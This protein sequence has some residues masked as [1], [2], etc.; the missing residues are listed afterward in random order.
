[1]NWEY[2]CKASSRAIRWCKFSSKTMLG[3]PG[4]NCRNHDTHDT[5]LQEIH[6]NF[7]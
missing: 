3:I 4:T 6:F 2:D 5:V 1:M 7:V